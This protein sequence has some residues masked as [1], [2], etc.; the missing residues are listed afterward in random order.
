MTGKEFK[1]V[2]DTIENEGFDYAFS[3]YTNFREEV[4]DPEFH[5]L[6]RVYLDAKDQLVAYIGMEEFSYND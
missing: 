2:L 6:R 5:R 4:K 3:G 1:Y